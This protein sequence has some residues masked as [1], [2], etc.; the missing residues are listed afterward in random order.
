LLLLLL[1]ILVTL[2]SLTSSSHAHTAEAK[3]VEVII[4]IVI[5]EAGERIPTTEEVSENFLRIS[6]CKE[7]VI[8]ESSE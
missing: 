8:W 3:G 7:I 6:E 1:P 2:I 4:F 5:E